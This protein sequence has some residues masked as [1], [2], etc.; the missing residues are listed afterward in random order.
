M[1]QLRRTLTLLAFVVS[2]SACSDT[3]PTSPQN[4]L[5]P[6]PLIEIA[7]TPDPTLV[8]FNAASCTLTNSFTGALSCNWNISNPS[9]NSLNLWAQAILTVNY[10]CVN[11]HNGR[12]A[13]SEQRDL[14]TIRQ[15]FGVSSATL[16]GTNV[17]LPQALLPTN[18]RGQ[19][20]KLNACKGNGVPMSLV[21][22][23]TYWDVSVITTSGTQRFSCFASDNRLGCLT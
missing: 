15:F 9:L 4:V 3:P 11:P 13:S 20:K 6:S 21:Y 14:E 22:S 18:L 8:T 2:S 12:I 19:D 5:A 10:D 16:T 7:V 1:S 17:A 23:L